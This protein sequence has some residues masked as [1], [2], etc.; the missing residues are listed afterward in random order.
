[1]N[2]TED[3]VGD[4]GNA[5]WLR[6]PPTEKRNEKYSTEY[7]MSWNVCDETSIPLR[8]IHSLASPLSLCLCLFHSSVARYIV[9]RWA[10]KDERMKAKKKLRRRRRQYWIEIEPFGK[11]LLINKTNNEMNG[12]MSTLRERERE[13][14]MK[15]EY[16]V[17]KTTMTTTATTTYRKSINV[18]E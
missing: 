2:G 16:E 10:V 14:R 7:S 9:M 4:V 1:M 17:T 15:F 18:D 3:L 13:A 8:Y 5:M 11:V 12:T 6:R